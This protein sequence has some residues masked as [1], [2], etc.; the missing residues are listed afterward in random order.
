MNLSGTTF[1][2]S[3]KHTVQHAPMH[4]SAKQAFTTFGLYSIVLLL[5]ILF[6]PLTGLRAEHYSGISSLVGMPYPA[7]DLP[8][9]ALD[10][11][12]IE[13]VKLDTT[14]SIKGVL[15]FRNTDSEYKSLEMV[16]PID[17]YLNEFRPELRSNLLKYLAESFPDLFAVTDNYTDIQQQLKANF[18]QR[19]FVR[20]SISRIDL[21]K[22]G[23]RSDMTRR[24]AAEGEEEL[25]PKKIGLEFRWVEAN[26]QEWSG[27]GQVL[28]ITIRI[29]HELLLKPS[30]KVQVDWNMDYPVLITGKDDAQ[31]YAPFSLAAEKRW[32]EK[33]KQLFLVNDLANS[34]LAI[35]TLY[36]PQQY[37]LGE[38]GSVAKF[39]NVNPQSE[40]RIAFYNKLEKSKSCT[41]DQGELLFPP[42]LG[43]VSASSW[44]N[45]TQSY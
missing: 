35:P 9:V 15:E 38:R 20:R 2:D 30:D 5:T 26:R 25:Y 45:R 19:L 22:M 31:F 29:Y 41:V 43:Q 39:T 3:S 23:I 6:S 33:I 28:K 8:G 16:V 27:T 34:V 21:A 32:N 1:P 37:M 18:G 4:K 24:G 40:V 14:S 17:M 7:K 44:L 36:T 10:N 42:A 11:A 12:I 13:M